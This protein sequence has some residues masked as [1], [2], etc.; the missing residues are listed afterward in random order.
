MQYLEKRGPK[1][2]DYIISCNSNSTLVVLSTTDYIP[3]ARIMASL[4]SVNLNSTTSVQMPLKYNTVYYLYAP[5]DTLSLF[6]LLLILVV[7]IRYRMVDSALWIT[8]HNACA[9]HATSDIYPDW[10]GCQ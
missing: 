3:D 1:I 4:R 8:I 2:Q 7:C 10:S 5:F 9:Y 6:H